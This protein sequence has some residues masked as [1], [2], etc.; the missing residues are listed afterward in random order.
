MRFW[1]V[2]TSCTCHGVWKCTAPHRAPHCMFFDHPTATVCLV[3]QMDSRQGV[4]HQPEAAQGLQSGGHQSA[5]RG[6]DRWR[7]HCI[8]AGPASLEGEISSF[9]SLRWRVSPLLACSWPSAQC[10]TALRTR[11]CKNACCVLDALHGWVLTESAWRPGADRFACMASQLI[12][13][14]VLSAN[15]LGRREST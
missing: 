7:T 1:L 15:S 2:C 5:A 6:G 3:L 12:T 14:F 13:H 4:G 8:C 10:R 11:E 9:L